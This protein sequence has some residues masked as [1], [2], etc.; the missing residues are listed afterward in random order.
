MEGTVEQVLRAVLA[1]V[2]GVGGMLL[3]YFGTNALVEQLGDKAKAHIRPWLFAGPALL[4]LFAFLV[5]PT[6]NTLYL[7]L[8]DNDPVHNIT[9]TFP[10]QYREEVVS[11][12][13]GR[14]GTIEDETT[15]E[16]NITISGELREGDL[17]GI[18]NFLSTL[19][20]DEGI[21]TSFT[22]ES[23]SL[24]TL[25]NYE[26]AFSAPTMIESF[27]NNLLWLILVPTL[28]TVLGLLIAVLAD[29]VKWENLAK[30]LIFLPMAISFVGASVIWRFIYFYRP[31]GEEQIGLL[32][33]ITTGLGSD[34]T[35]W[36]TVNPINN[37]GLIIILVWIQTG[38]AMVLL[39]AALKA[40]PEE[41]IEA[42]RIDGAGEIRI[43]FNIIVPQIMGTVF[44][45]MTTI[46]ILV[47][48]VFDIPYVMTS[49]EFGTE[50]LANVMYDQMF[51]FG[52]Y[53]RGS[54]VAIILMV[55]VIPIMIINIRRFRREEAMR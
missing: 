5:Y 54:T 3:Y 4:V 6:F 29:R 39:S 16:G 14:G 42:A 24:F 26:W 51:R 35:A 37:L 13:E 55:A 2:L 22:D 46:I 49:G 15:A 30:A 45:V 53:P 38:F 17:N 8:T 40:V 43:F 41:T 12:Y 18:R 48:K 19:E 11:F 32:N 9:M 10:E 47:L 1:I 44:V 31:P 20:A 33:A 28:S 27:G 52:N 50:V 23:E 21:E 36:L 34:P 25:R 7:S